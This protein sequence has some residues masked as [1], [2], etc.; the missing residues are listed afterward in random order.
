MQYGQIPGRTL[1]LYDH[2]RSRL[3]VFLRHNMIIARR[4]PS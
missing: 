2:T 1:T 3:T 4:L